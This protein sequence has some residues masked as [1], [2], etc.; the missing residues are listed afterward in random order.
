MKRDREQVFKN[1]ANSLAVPHLFSVLCALTSECLMKVLI[2]GVKMYLA[3]FGDF[4]MFD[5]NLMGF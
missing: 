4:C 1:V 2:L 3:L 5:A